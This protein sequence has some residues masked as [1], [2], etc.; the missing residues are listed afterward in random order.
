MV[1]PMVNGPAV[2]NVLTIETSAEA[3]AVP[4]LPLLSVLFARFGS[5]SVALTV[6]LLS[7]APGALI[8]AVTVIVSVAPLAIE[9]MVQGRP[10]QFVLVALLIVRFDGVSVIC[11]FVAVDGPLFVTSSVYWMV[12]PW[13]NGPAAVN[14]LTID[15]SADAPVR[16][17]LPVLSVLLLESG[18]NSVA[19]TVAL[20]S[21]EMAS[22]VAVTVMISIAPFASDG[23][24]QGKAEQFVLLTPVMV[25]LPG[26]S[27]TWTFVAVDGPL[28]PATTE[29]W[30]VWPSV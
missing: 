26:V 27:V 23:I 22:M 9:A 15:M 17:A 14:V 28:L 3:A 11:T 10:E 12:C 8:V 18:S 13:M 7:N 16:P 4:P 6:A 19:E 21:K 2:V 25:R 24:V 1:W 5:P 20:L 30:I 29:Y